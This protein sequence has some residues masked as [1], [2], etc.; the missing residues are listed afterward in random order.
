MYM[1]VHVLIMRHDICNCSFIADG[2]V[3][4]L[5]LRG[6]G[7][8]TISGNIRKDPPNDI[9]VTA[10]HVVSCSTTSIVVL[11]VVASIASLVFNTRDVQSLACSTHTFKSRV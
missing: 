1:Y 9:H 3:V 5:L 2:G 10:P 6:R 4:L 8:R 11:R 7:G